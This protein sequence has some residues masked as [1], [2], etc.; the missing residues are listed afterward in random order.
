[1]VLCQ[2]ADA[3]TISW[4]D[5]QAVVAGRTMTV[6]TRTGEQLR[7]NL[8]SQDE[9]GLRLAVSG[10]KPRGLQAKNSIVRV[11][12]G[13]LRRIRVIKDPSKVSGRIAGS[14]IGF[15]AG[16]YIGTILG[17]G[18]QNIGGGIGFLGGPVLGFFLGRAVDRE[19]IDLSILDLAS[20]K[21]EPIPAPQSARLPEYLQPHPDAGI[22]G[23]LVQPA[24]R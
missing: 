5:L 12:R 17:G 2:G 3:L 24:T 16:G 23:P 22:P 1:M 4:A 6:D 21:P 20:G 7:G 11:E 8:L 10:A 14:F 15:F 18:E 19:S 9:L 13:Q